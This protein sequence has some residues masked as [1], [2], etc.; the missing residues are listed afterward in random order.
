MVEE[1]L[2]YVNQG[3]AIFVLAWFMFRMEKII[4]RNTESIEHLKDV[5]KDIS[6][7]YLNKI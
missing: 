5:I 6:I 3:V 2:P 4:N 7:K 1:W